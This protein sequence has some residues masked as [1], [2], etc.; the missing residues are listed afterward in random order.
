M[1][2]EPFANRDEMLRAAERVWWALSPAD[3]LEAFAAH[4]RIGDAGAN[5]EQ[6]GVA[7]GAAETL[8]RRAAGHPSY[9]DTLG[10]LY[11]GSAT[12]RGRV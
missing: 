1:A 7:G 3:W 2:L 8:A 5:E 9:E 11:I 6:A 12:W 10:D 4:P